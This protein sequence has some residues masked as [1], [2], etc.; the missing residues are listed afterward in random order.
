M[1]R[2]CSVHACTT[3]SLF[4]NAPFR[5]M[6]ICVKSSAHYRQEMK[7]WIRRF[8]SLGRKAPS[9]D[10]T[11]AMSIALSTTCW[12]VS[13]H[14]SILDKDRAIWCGL[15]WHVRGHG[16]RSPDFRKR[17]FV[18]SSR[19]DDPA[20]ARLGRIQSS[21]ILLMSDRLGPRS[22]SA[23][24]EKAYDHRRYEHLSRQKLADWEKNVPVSN[25][26]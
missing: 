21:I 15:L 9:T 5:L 16:G 12:L 19:A 17:I 22:S 7:R 4:K 1:W 6:T 25:R 11:L 10:E 8:A 20:V 13:G 3:L 24:F 14:R 23:P 18:A 26:Q 2:S